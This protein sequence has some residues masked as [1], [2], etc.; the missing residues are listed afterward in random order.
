MI[1]DVTMPRSALVLCA[2]LLVQ[3]A[4]AARMLPEHSACPDDGPDGGSPA[5][6]A[7]CVCCPDEA[8]PGRRVVL[9]EPPSPRPYRW[10]GPARAVAPSPGPDE[11]AHV[12]KTALA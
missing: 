1:G 6:V 8:P 10:H 12:P 5:T 3:A 2:V 11:I 4:T 9:A 7:S